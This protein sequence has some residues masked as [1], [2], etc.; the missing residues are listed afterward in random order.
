MDFVPRDVDVRSLMY[1]ADL[2]EDA[3]DPST[4]ER[5]KALLSD[6]G[7][8]GLAA[9]RRR[10]VRR[11]LGYQAPAIVFSEREREDSSR[12]GAEPLS[13]LY[14]LSAS[15][16]GQLPVRAF[17][18]NTAGSI[19]KSLTAATEAGRRRIGDGAGTSGDGDAAATVSPAQK[20]RA[21]FVQELLLSTIGEPLSDLNPGPLGAET[22]S[23]NKV[24][25]KP[26]D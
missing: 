17:R 19:L 7:E 3:G 9:A 16:K 15:R 6:A 1:G 21:V 12:I 23:T 14:H 10:V 20:M 22:E 25:D 11:P 24:P 2:I 13:E 8:R 18:D 5:M 26:S 4:E